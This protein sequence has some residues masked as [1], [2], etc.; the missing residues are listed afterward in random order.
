MAAIITDDF[1]KI[2]IDRFFD[3]VSK[4]HAAGGKDYYIGIGKTDP[5]EDDDA[6][7]NEINEASFSPPT[8]VGSVID[9]KDI[10]KNLMTLKLVEPADVKRM[11]P[12]IRFT[13]GTK[14]KV[15]NPFDPTCFDITDDVMPCYVTYTGAD[16]RARIYAC[17]GN[18]NNAATSEVIGSVPAGNTPFG[19]VQNS[20]DKYIWAYI[21]DWDKHVPAN[22]FSSSRTFMNLPEDDVI[23]TTLSTDGITDGRKRAVQASGGLLY[24]FAISAKRPGANYPSG[25]T[26]H[27]RTGDNALDAI[28]VGE[29]LDGTKITAN[30][31]C[32]VETGVGGTIT[33]VIWNLS[34]AQTLGYSKASTK[35]ST[36]T[37]GT[38]SSGSWTSTLSGTNG[39]I[40]FA[41]LIIN[42]TEL[43][44]G[45]SPSLQGDFDAAGFSKAEIIPLIAPADGFGH[46][47]LKDLPSY[48]AGISSNF[49]G[50]VGDNAE[51]GTQAGDP[52]FVAEALVD[53]K[54]RE[55]SLLRDGNDD[56]V[57]KDSSGD[58]K[59]DDSPYPDSSFNPE[60]A[61]N[62]L[63]YFQVTSSDS[64]IQSAA[65][66]ANSFNGAYIQQVGSD[67]Q[68]ARAFLDQVSIYE[69]LDPADG[70][71]GIQG[72]FRVYFHQNSSRLINEKIF[73]AN[74]DITLHQPNGTQ[75]GGALTYASIRDGE[76]VPN[77][78]EVLFVDKKKPITRNEQ[79][80]EEVRLIIQF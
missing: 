43:T 33:R 12:Q 77:T 49:E 71:D 25:S 2:N 69:S 10:K 46:S 32:K 68:K 80:T 20:T 72:G 76:Y 11:V 36:T 30:N 7:V 34:N 51:A 19:V 6:G 3:D 16:N 62:C 60:Q 56:M 44:V 24:G 17:L 65:A 58:D 26:G 22:K 15:Y 73:T 13:V 75:I 52:Q 5:Y 66:A 18:N 37:G 29:H 1:R 55:V 74:G 54:F 40:K 41:S 31:T 70:G 48:Y 23:D 53:V 38:S 9:K 67:T 4:S 42:D 45:G 47:P 50:P 57:F 35:A 79:Q 78:G 63:R 39:G 8:P 14:Y 59:E 21:C 64:N 61:L 27:P 28:I